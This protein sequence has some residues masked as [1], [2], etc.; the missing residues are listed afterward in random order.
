MTTKTT[1]QTDRLAHVAL[2]TKSTTKKRPKLIGMDAHKKAVK[3][4]MKSGTHTLLIGGAGTGK[5][6]LAQE[7]AYELGRPWYRINLNGY[8]T[9]DQLIGRMQAKADHGTT[10]FFQYGVLVQAM[11]E[12]AVLILDEVNSALPDTLFCL[13]PV[14]EDISRLFVPETEEEILPKD[15]F[16]IIGTMNPCH[17][18]AG[19]RELN[20][21]FFSRF[22]VV[23]R[24]E[25]LAGASLLEA[26]R[27]HAPSDIGDQHLIN[28]AEV[29][30]SSR[31]ARKADKI[32]S[33][34]TLRECISAL[35]LMTELTEEEAIESAMLSK[36]ELDEVKHVSK[37]SM[38]RLPAGKT[39]TDLFE[40]ATLADTYKTQLAKAEKEL[41]KLGKLKAL[42]ET[43]K[44]AV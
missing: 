33:M 6:S 8:V 17:D 34:L 30:E 9:P 10:T 23:R 44:G 41:E 7:C 39:L 5:T 25:D 12:G 35:Q 32:T 28:V 19:T 13:H 38:T 42:M 15:G 37:R 22:R 14:L 43:M 20:G 4:A 2:A 3:C 11:R 16:C 1:E 21:A 40:E 27:E 31:R 26:L 36:L 29:L 18:Y 24:F